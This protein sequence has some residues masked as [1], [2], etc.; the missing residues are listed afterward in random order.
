[1]LNMYTKLILRL[2]KLDTHEIFTQNYTHKLYTIL[3][4]LIQNILYT[5]YT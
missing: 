1:M 4:N 3:I 2:Y 5:D